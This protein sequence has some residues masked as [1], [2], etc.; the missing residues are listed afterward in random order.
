MGTDDAVRSGVAR[1]PAATRLSDEFA[2]VLTG[3]Q[4]AHLDEL[5][6]GAGGPVGRKNDEQ[7]HEVGGQLGG[8]Y[9]VGD[10][11]AQD[12]ADDR[13]RQER[14]G[15]G[16]EDVERSGTKPECHRRIDGDDHQ[17]HAHRVGHRK[18]HGEHQRRD[19]EVHGLVGGRAQA[20]P[21][22]GHFPGDGKPM[23]AYEVSRHTVREAVRRLS[24]YGLGDFSRTALYAELAERVGVQPCSGWERIHPELPTPDQRKALG[25]RAKQLVFAIERV[26]YGPGA[27]HLIE[28]RHSI[29]RGD[30]FAFVARWDSRDQGTSGAMEAEVLD[31]G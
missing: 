14:Q 7:N 20:A 16:P 8:G 31:P 12:L 17:R 1:S 11:F 13:K 4:L 9:P 24:D 6:D 3:R 25:I 29:V 18:G 23:A 10:A 22:D 21:P 5:N 28:W 30:S 19:D 2:L 27:A 15:V 26:A